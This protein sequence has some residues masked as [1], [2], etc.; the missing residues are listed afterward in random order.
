PLLGTD[1]K[2]LSNLYV[3]PTCSTAMYLYRKGSWQKQYSLDLRKEEREHIITILNDAIDTLGLRPDRLWGEMIEDRITQI[4]ISTLGQEAPIEEKKKYD[5]DF[6]KRKQIRDYMLPNLAGFNVLI[7][8]ATSIDITREGVDKA[9]GIRKLME[10]SGVAMNEIIF[11]GDAVF[12]GGNDYPPLEA[13]VTTK[14]VFTVEDTKEY[15]RS[16]IAN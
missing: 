14:R 9:Y 11:V 15:I 7:A 12:P 1:E 6:S 3:C 2:L 16:L 13:G 4:T 8:G 10:V 5:P